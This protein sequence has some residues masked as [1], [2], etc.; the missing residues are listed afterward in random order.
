MLKLLKTYT[1]VEERSSVADKKGSKMGDMTKEEWLEKATWEGGVIQGLEYGL[2]ASD[3]S[4]DVDEEFRNN[5]A[6]AEKLYQELEPLL[7]EIEADMEV[8]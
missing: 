6:Q 1:I 4:E 7:R 2:K 5:V 3:L 8:W